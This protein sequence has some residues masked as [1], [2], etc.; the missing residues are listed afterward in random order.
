MHRRGAD[1]VL[2]RLLHNNLFHPQPGQP[3]I[4]VAR[5]EYQSAGNGG[6]HHQE[7]S[8]ILSEH[9]RNHL[10]RL[11]TLWNAYTHPT[12]GICLLYKVCLDIENPSPG[13]KEQISEIAS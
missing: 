3:R 8:G 9:V 5:M 2:R 6:V 1:C 12:W 4:R 10:K 7:R 11:E 13:E